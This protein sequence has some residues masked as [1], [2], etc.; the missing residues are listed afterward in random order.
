MRV[1][2]PPS[3]GDRVSQL[4]DRAAVKKAISGVIKGMYIVL[5]V[6]AI[7]V[8]AVIYG[9]YRLLLQALT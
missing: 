3:A 1:S 5:G 4:N 7:V 9:L 2:G 6:Y 8:L